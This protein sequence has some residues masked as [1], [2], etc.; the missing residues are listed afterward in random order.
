[1]PVR[2]ARPH[3]LLLLVALGGCDAWDRS[4]ELAGRVEQLEEQLTTARNDVMKLRK[5]VDDLEAAAAAPRPV[6]ADVPTAFDL[7]MPRASAGEDLEPVMVL[8]VDPSTLTLNGMVVSDDD[9]DERL[10][11]LASGRPDCKLILQADRD[12]AYA[13]IVALLDRAKTAGI[14]NIALATAAELAVPEPEPEPEPA[15]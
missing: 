1:M 15:K 13:R 9:L 12:V 6:A 8:S 14:E 7:R 2:P 10:K 5:R 3:V 11:E 4:D